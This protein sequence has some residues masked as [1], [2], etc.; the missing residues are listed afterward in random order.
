MSHRDTSVAIKEDL[1]WS[2]PN[3]KVWSQPVCFNEDTINL[4]CN[5]SRVS[6][7]NNLFEIY[8]LQVIVK[9]CNYNSYVVIYITW[10]RQSCYITVKLDAIKI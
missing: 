4:H 9:I 1:N 3:T 8:M 10:L 2:M 7:L 6:V 5:Q